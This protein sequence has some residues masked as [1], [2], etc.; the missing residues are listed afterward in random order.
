MQ[1][2]DAIAVVLVVLFSIISI[3]ACTFYHFA[4][5]NVGRMESQRLR[6]LRGGTTDT[7]SGAQPTEEQRENAG[8]AGAVSDTVT[9]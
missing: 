6:R 4:A 5:R 3:I 1:P 8:G 2:N 7:R 9:A